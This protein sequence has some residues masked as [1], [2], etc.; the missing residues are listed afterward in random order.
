MNRFGWG[1]A[2]VFLVTLVLVL[3]PRTGLELSGA[4]LPSPVRAEK[5]LLV[6]PVEGVRREDLIDTW[7]QSREDGARAHQAIDIAAPRGTRVRAALPGR[8]D[9][10]FESERGGRTIYIRS[11]DGRWMT[12]YAHLDA[13]AP[14]LAEGQSVLQGQRIGTVG[15]SG[16]AEPGNTHLHFALHR[17]RPGERWWRGVPVNPYP[18]LAGT[19][20]AR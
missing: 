12:Y 17:M 4:R 16:N 5:P 8:V 20:A 9:R 7:G 10:L 1:I 13:Y 11:H 15:D 18:L 2:G 3:W 14:G 19:A 6:M